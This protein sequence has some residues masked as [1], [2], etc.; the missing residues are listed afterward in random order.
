VKPGSD[1][2]NLTKSINNE[3]M[4][5]SKSDIVIFWGGSNDVYKNNSDIGLNHIIKFV[6]A[7]SHTNIILLNV[8]HRY[9]LIESSCVN[10]EITRFNRK[11]AK[12][13]KLYGYCTLVN[14]DLNK[15]LF[16]KHGLHLN[17]LGKEVVMKQ[18]VCHIYDRMFKV[19]PTQI[20]LYWKN[21][22]S[23]QDL[24]RNSSP[25]EMEI[26]VEV[27]SQTILNLDHFSSDEIEN[28]MEVSSQTVLNE[29]CSPSD[30]MESCV[31]VSSLT[32][33]NMDHSSS[34]E[35][36]NDVEVSSETILNLDHSSL[37]EL[38][39]CREISSQMILNLDRSSLNEMESCVEVSNQALVD[40]DHSSRSSA[41][42]S[43]NFVANR[44]SNRIRRTP[45]TRNKDFLW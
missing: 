25:D 11:L 4:N 16:T 32:V 20:G 39:N 33:L 17:G 26:C 19:P 38:E 6:K 40:S 43:I 28:C 2:D 37:D 3:V 18:L 21:D 10:K 31:K 41:T 29:D 22:L 5:L 14:V 23:N 45:V 7:C 15:D 42:N 12:S 8:P 36:E 13:T 34:D 27:S 1:A 44:S 35:L 30:E 9:D 24:E